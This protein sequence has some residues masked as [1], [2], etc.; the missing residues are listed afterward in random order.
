MED[1]VANP[2]GARAEVSLL[3]TT[4]KTELQKICQQAATAVQR[5]KTGS[6]EN[7]RLQVAIRRS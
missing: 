4:F 2:L 5:A 6:L 7:G 1:F 3:T